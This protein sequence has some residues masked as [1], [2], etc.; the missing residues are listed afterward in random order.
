MKYTFIQAELMMY[1]LSVVCPLLGVTQSGF[2]FWRRREPSTREQESQ[3]LRIQIRPIFDANRGR[4]GAPRIYKAMCTQHGYTGSLNRIQTLMRRMGIKAKAGR[5]FKV[6]TDS[7]HS[8]PIAPNL[9]GQNFSCDPRA[10]ST[11]HAKAPDQVWLSD[12]TYLWTREGWLYVCAV[13]DLY[14]RKIVGWA[15]AAHM[16]REL[17]LDALRMANT[18]RW[19]PPGL[20]F[21]SDR[22]SQYA[23]LEVRAWL[24]AQAMRQSMSGTGNCYDNA[25]MESFWHSL[26]VEETHGIDFATR[27]EARHCV[28][29]YIEGWYN[30][31]RMHSSLGYKSPSQFEREGNAKLTK[32]A[33]DELS[34]TLNKNSQSARRIKRAA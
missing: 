10:E 21:H 31:T 20:I 19:P 4:Y 30:T 8:L 32:A 1:P 2:H 14:T 24:L 11:S 29:E 25:P 5:K 12:I 3:Q 26:K 6:T 13:L 7:T 16:T 9:L 23:S 27:A 18:V 15:M 28:F 34:T 33:N 17:V 22:G